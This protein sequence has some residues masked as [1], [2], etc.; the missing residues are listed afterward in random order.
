[1][2]EAGYV[3]V[4]DLNIQK[5]TDFGEAIDRM[6]REAK[7]VVVLWTRASAASE[8]VRKEANEAERL[9]KYLGVRIDA[10]TPGELP[11]QVRNN[12]W[13]DLSGASLP[14]GLPALLTEVQRLA[15]QTTKDAATAESAAQSAEK[16][17]EFYQVVSE[18]GDVGGFRKYLQLYPNGAY[19]DDA[20]SH[21]RR[22]SGLNAI[23]RA[24]PIFSIIT[25][26]GTGVGAYVALSGSFGG[27][28]GTSKLTAERDAA[29]ERLVS[30]E[31]QIAKLNAALSELRARKPA[32]TDKTVTFDGDSTILSARFDPLNN[33]LRE[34]FKVDASMRRGVVVTGMSISSPFYKAGLKTGDLIAT[35][36][37]ETVYSAQQVY[38]VLNVG[39]RN[40]TDVFKITALRQS[41]GV[42]AT[43]NL[44]GYK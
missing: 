35:I 17:L 19:V 28:T 4:T 24:I 12:N 13:L 40:G 30:A 32:G 34:K 6:I 43:L 2:K 20:K 11:L 36:N 39:L 10:V 5:A 29:I 37:G 31:E 26:I 33:A 27:S 23:V 14:Q 9:G 18:I 42:S 15:G 3:A 7:V 22:R 44:Q 41:S 8:W 25:A 21:I 16:D 1:M 38:N